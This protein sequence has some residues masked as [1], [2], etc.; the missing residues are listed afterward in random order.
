MNYLSA[1]N[2]SK[3]Y[4]DKALF[5]GLSFGLHK[6]EKTALIANNGTGKS[7]LLRILAGKE[8]PDTGQ[9]TLRD[10]IKTA[11][12]EQDPYFELGFTI[13]ELIASSHGSVSKV[14]RDYND[15]IQAESKL[16]NTETQ[17]N[18]EKAIAGMDHMQAW[19]YERRLKQLL[20]LF[21]ITDTS[22][23]IDVLSGGE[24]KRLALA[25]VLL[26]E[27]ELLILDEPTNHLDVDMIEW[28][29]AYLSRANLTLLM[30][31]HDRYFLDRV[32]NHILEMSHGQL[33][34]HNGNY[35]YF[36]QKKAER[37]EI[38]QVETDKARQLMKKELEWL[39]RQPKARTHKSK[40][41][42]QAFDGIKEKAT[43]LKK[44]QELDLQL[45]VTRIGGKILEIEH[46]KKSYGNT[47]IVE[48]FSYIFK[49]G[50]RI[51]II[52]KNGSGK[53][54]FLNLIT[55]NEKPDSGRIETGQTVVFGYYRQTGIKLADDKKVIDVVKE[56]AEVVQMGDGNT[57]SASRF[58]ELFMFP[59]EVQYKQVGLL[60]GG[61]KRRLNLLTVLIKNPNFLIL[62]EPTN[63]L[64]L[65]V[66]NRLE[67]FLLNYSGCLIL[68]SHDRYFLNKLTDH[69]FIFEGTGRVRD[70]Y[71]S[72]AKYNFEKEQEKRLD[73]KQNKQQLPVTKKPARPKVK[74]KL[75]FNE[76]REYESL[77]KEIEQ[78][79]KEKAEAET[80]MNSGIEDYEELN[81]LSSRIGEL[82]ELIDTKTL[83]WIE[84]DEFSNT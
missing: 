70:Y 63:D 21:S 33:Y 50:E 17:K 74:T 6:G 18:L 36:L 28:L 10:G 48:D 22:A 27:P 82:M 24:K 47:K 14:I 20:N 61:E 30:V 51:G 66:L 1:E 67:E 84:L 54:S 12:L 73:E 52:G 60:S 9:V 62:D 81:K 64:D 3:T 26:D 59:P 56:I 79:E 76:Q 43:S 69:L 40:S 77:E 46:L 39:R 80:L 25:L 71:G 49:K 11:F 13:D 42:I 19:D 2:L 83:R 31:T 55:G 38:T 34:Y 41:R 57:I 65:L 8:T 45:N 44:E 29:E 7:T 35:E 68:V 75:S 32:C 23:Q 72:Y 15:A 58:L 5:E 16:H 37:D 4:G 53:T 78:L